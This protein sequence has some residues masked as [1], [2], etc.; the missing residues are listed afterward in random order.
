MS[1]EED[2]R[3]IA[4]AIIG[5]GLYMVLGTADEAGNPWTSPVYYAYEGV[6]RFL[7][8]SRRRNAGTPGTSPCGP[9]SAS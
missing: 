6:A 3:A 2:P 8:V 7:W 1:R 4:R 9:R 5:S